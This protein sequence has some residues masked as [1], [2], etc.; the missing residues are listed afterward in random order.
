MREGE[1][2]QFTAT[3]VQ[4]FIQQAVKRRESELKQEFEVILAARLEGQ[5]FHAISFVFC[6]SVSIFV[7]C[8]I[9]LH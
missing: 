2:P 4:E 1:Q 9:S 6:V 7:S 3:Q 8:F 5:F